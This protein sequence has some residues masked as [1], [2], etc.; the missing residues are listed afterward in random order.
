MGKIQISETF[1]I[2]VYNALVLPDYFKW[3]VFENNQ[4]IDHD[5]GL[6]KKERLSKCDKNAENMRPG[7]LYK[8]VDPLFPAVDFV[9]IKEIQ[10]DKQNKQVYCVQVTF[11]KDHKKAQSVYQQLYNR[12]GMDSQLDEIFVYIITQPKHVDGYAT[13]TYKKLVT[14]DVSL[15]RL[16]F[17]AVKQT[18]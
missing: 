12:L 13:G 10:K 9:F 4:W 15:P 17:S 6:S 14:G 16:H 8:P 1:E 11:S 2:V 5:W 7:I 18:C 3:Q